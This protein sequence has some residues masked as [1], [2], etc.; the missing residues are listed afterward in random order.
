MMKISCFFEMI[1]LCATRKSLVT[2]W[3]S[4]IHGDGPVAILVKIYC[5]PGTNK[6]VASLTHVQ[7]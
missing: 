4:A 6:W 3:C 2:A 5:N 1:A 7:N